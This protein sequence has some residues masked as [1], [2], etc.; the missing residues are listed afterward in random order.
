MM[1]SS[2]ETALLK[3][4]C[5]LYDGMDGGRVSILVTLDI[6]AAFDT[7]DASILLERM[8]VYFGVSGKALQWLSSYL[9]QKRQCV[10]V[11]GVLSPVLVLP[12]GVPQGSVLGPVLFSAFIAPLADVIDSFHILH[13]QYA[14]DM[15]LYH[16]FSASHQQSCLE[17]VSECL[18]LVNNWFLTNGL[19]VNQSKSNSI[20]IGT[21]VQ[22]GKV[23]SSGV[24]I[25]GAKIPLSE[26]IKSLGVVFDQGL[27]FE[28][29]VKAVCRTCYFH[30]KSLRMLR[31]S[32]DTGTA[33]TIGRSII[34]SRLDY[35]NSLLVFT[36][37]RNIHRLQMVQNQ[38]ARVVS[39]SSY[40]QSAAPILLSLRWLPVQ[41]RIEYKIVNMVFKSRINFL[42]EYLS[43]GL[44][45]YTSVHRSCQIITAEYICCA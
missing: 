25:G 41:Q 28:D 5:D 32:L 4:A 3:V 2:S 38:L 36:S 30:I 21:S 9:T 34:M 14:D 29:H 40:R 31:P 20:F 7:I 17:S 18:N 43:R 12:S 10:R 24:E 15:N 44:T 39:G 13:H 26:N 6:S 16:S 35:C 22:T 33:E 1:R 37:K 45:V 19:L 11:D 42:P 23:D 27:T 8:V